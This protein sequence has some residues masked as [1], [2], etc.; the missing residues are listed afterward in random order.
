MLWGNTLTV[1]NTY[2]LFL[3]GWIQTI[4]RTEPDYRIH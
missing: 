3:F 1:Q 4:R 2:G